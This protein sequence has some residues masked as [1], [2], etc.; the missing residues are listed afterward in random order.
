VQHAGEPDVGGVAR[1]AANAL[2][3]VLARRRPADNLAG[4]F[5]PLLERI[6]LDDEPDFLESPFDLFLGADQPCQLRIASSI[7][8]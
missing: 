4:A 8:G 5:R 6:L 1:F 2:E 3:R 7:F